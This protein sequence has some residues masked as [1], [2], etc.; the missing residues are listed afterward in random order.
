GAHSVKAYETEIEQPGKA[1]HDVEPQPQ[2]H[3]DEHQRGDI[4]FRPPG[5]EG[6]DQRDG[7]QQDDAGPTRLVIEHRHADGAA[8]A[9]EHFLTRWPNESLEHE[10]KRHADQHHV[11]FGLGLGL[12]ADAHDP[13]ATV[14]RN[15]DAGHAGRDKGVLDMTS[16]YTF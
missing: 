16:H 6:P 11:P 2:H 1:D 9:A 10:T 3:V 8:L 5:E 13:Q 4:D 7:D 14:R 15:D 12:H